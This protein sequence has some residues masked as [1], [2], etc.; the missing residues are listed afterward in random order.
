MVS[1]LG[2][3]QGYVKEFKVANGGH[4]VYSALDEEGNRANLGKNSHI[5]P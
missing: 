5:S 3:H 4:I 2:R 1:K